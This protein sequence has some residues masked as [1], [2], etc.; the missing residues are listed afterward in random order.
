VFGLRVGKLQGVGLRE[1]NGEMDQKDLQWL[2]EQDEEK[3]QLGFRIIQNAF[4]GK[5]GTLESEVRALK[6]A[7]DEKQQALNGLQKKNSSL[8]VEIIEMHQKTQQMSEENKTLLSTVRSL[9][10]QI[11]KLERLKKTFMETIDDYGTGSNAGTDRQAQLFAG[12]DYLRG[13]A[14]MT[15]GQ[16]DGNFSNPVFQQGIQFGKM[17]T[18]G[19][20]SISRAEFL[21]G[22]PQPVA[23]STTSP[24]PASPQIDGKAFFRMAR[25][26]LAYEDFNTFLAN[27]KR[28]NSHQQTRDQTLEAA[29]KLFGA[30]NSD[31]YTDFQALLNRHS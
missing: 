3:L 23:M 22:S 4:K 24:R 14:P 12:D 17:D 31:L 9:R 30:Q 27:I 6:G 15:M 28:L 8:E 16:A 5:V 2:P 26:K 1:G 18:D 10:A 11:E 29:R 20:G 19:N 21:A 7:N 13:A 25:G